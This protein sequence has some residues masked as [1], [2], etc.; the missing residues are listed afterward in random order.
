MSNQQKQTIKGIS[1][2]D[3]ELKEDT[4]SLYRTV[5]SGF[6]RKKQFRIV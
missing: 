5:K 1:I 2:K 6:I 3:F 4:Q